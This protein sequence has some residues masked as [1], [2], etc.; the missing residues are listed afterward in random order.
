ME[1]YTV[2]IKKF[3]KVIYVL[4]QIAFIFCIVGGAFGILLICWRVFELPMETILVNGRLME[5]PVLFKLG[6]VTVSLPLLLSENNSISLFNWQEHI[7]KYG[8][9]DVISIIVF[10]VA[11]AYGKRIFKM[12][13]EDGSPFRDEVVKGLKNMAVALLVTGILTGLTGVLSAGIVWVISLIFEYGCALQ[14]ESDTTL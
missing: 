9:S 6:N 8:F 10:I 4:L 12:L 13:R 7:V 2:K 1:N 3:S 14:K 11:L 5:T